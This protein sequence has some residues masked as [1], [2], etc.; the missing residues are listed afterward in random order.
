MLAREY[1]D[2]CKPKRLKPVILSHPMMPGLLEVGRRERFAAGEKQ[3]EGGAIPSLIWLHSSP[4]SISHHPSPCLGRRARTAALSHCFVLA[5]A[6][7]PA[8]FPAPRLPLLLQGQEK[9]SKSDPNSAIFME[10]S[11]QEVK[12][13][14]KK[15]FCPPQQVGRDA[16][17]LGGV[18]AS[19]AVLGESRES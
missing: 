5:S 7:S 2:D 4:A 1:C 6:C 17:R 11:E 14:I 16:G 15:A 10:D 12:T 18:D 9:M 3:L 8:P 19:S 13:K